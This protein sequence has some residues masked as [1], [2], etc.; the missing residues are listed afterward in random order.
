MLKQ[1][2]TFLLYPNLS[3]EPRSLNVHG[4]FVLLGRFLLAYFGLA[5]LSSLIFFPILRMM[6]LLPESKIATSEIPLSFKLIVFVPIYEEAIFRLP[7]RFTKRNLAISLAA[8]FFL[9]FYHVF[10]LY[11]LIAIA[12]FIALIPSFI[13]IPASAILKA[14][15]VWRRYFP[16]LYYGLALSF[17][18][19]H[20]FNFENLRLAH[21]FVFPLIVFNQI[22]MGLMLGYIRV[23]YKYGFIYGI[24][25]HFL[26]N[27][28]LI[29][30]YHL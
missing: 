28:P 19:L 13:V 15:T 12:A 5:I 9:V 14:G 8:L 2:F 7:L 20:L 1:F 29:L 17:G 21:F 16:V 23:E 25:L 22:I 3:T 18:I 11:T 26:I 24:I 6:D 10:E 30:L 4:L 27:L